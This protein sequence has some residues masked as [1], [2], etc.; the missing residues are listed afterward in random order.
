MT[1][2]TFDNNK[3]DL[4]QEAYITDDGTE[5]TALALDAEGEECHVFWAIYPEILSGESDDQGDQSNLCDWDKPTR[6]A[7]S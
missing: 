6:V 5:Y 7:R 1:T 2:I 3:I 4:Q